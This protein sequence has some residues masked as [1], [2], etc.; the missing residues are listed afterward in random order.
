MR[1]AT[2]VIGQKKTRKRANRIMKI[3]RKKLDSNDPKDWAPCD[4]CADEVWKRAVWQVT[5][6]FIRKAPHGGREHEVMRVYYFCQRHME[7]Y[8]LR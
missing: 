5:T 6:T 4:R 3:Q 8:D 1:N 2:V 7:K